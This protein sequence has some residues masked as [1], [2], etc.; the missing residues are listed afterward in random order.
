MHLEN[1][2]ILVSATLLISYISSLFYTVTKIPDVIFLMG[3]GILMGPGLGYVS[4]GLFTEL[5]PIMSIIALSI[6]LFE[7]GINVKIETL[8][9]HMGKA[10]IL[11]FTTIF[12]A[13]LLVGF[14]MNYIFMPES[15]TLLQ[16]ML[17][18][19]MIGGTS[20]VAVYGIMEGI[21]HSVE[22]TV[23]TRVLLTME[24]IISDP[25][26]IISSIT[27]IQMIMQPGVS[28]SEAFKDIFSTFTL[29]SAFG[30]FSGIVWAKVLDRLRKRPHTYMITLA[31][32]FPLYIL[33]EEA[34]GEGG[35]AM[36]ALS[37]GLGITN[38]RYLMGK[39]G[40][41]DKVLIDA[42]RLREFH[43]E[44]T[45][46]VKSFFFVYIGVVVS[47]SIRFA[48]IGF[49]IVIILVA[50]RFF[51]VLGLSKPFLFTREERVL[52]QVVYAS[53]L[54]AFVMSQL[55]EIFDPTGEFFLTPGIYPDLCMPIVLGTIIFSGLI[56]PVFAKR[57]IDDEIRGEREGQKGNNIAEKDKENDSPQ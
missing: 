8:M 38:Y 41:Q 49:S 50:M 27:L 46:F 54:P 33:A 13:I 24:S 9:E 29:S 10:M 35:G 17:L 11:S 22:N 15:F 43:E 30:L 55:P 34:I 52:S 21:G 44:I 16:G 32:L 19:A 53:G 28:L 40:I 47:L 18:G 37:F 14:S 20:T 3:F 5:A 12:S 45:F 4:K 48:F 6:I 42:R 25:V 23:S 39:F 2:I 56:G 36:A 7:A 26:C 1:I 57:A 51:L 31:I